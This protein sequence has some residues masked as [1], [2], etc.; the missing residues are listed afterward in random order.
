MLHTQLLRREQEGRPIRVGIIGAGTFGTQIVA[1]TCRMKGMR[2]SAIAD[3]QPERG[4]R[5]LELGGI[6]RGVVQRADSASDIDR[7]LAADRPA[8]TTSVSELLASQI[9]VVIEATGN[10]EAG[11]RHA[12]DAIEARKHVVMVT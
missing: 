6:E 7:A 1:Q 8:V 9:D 3:L 11:A 5:A 12:Y 4:L 2:I 10:P